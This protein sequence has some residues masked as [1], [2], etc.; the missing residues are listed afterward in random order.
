VDIT[1]ETAPLSEALQV[2]MR[3]VTARATRLSG[4]ILLKAATPG[5]LEVLGTDLTTVFSTKLSA[6]VRS[7][8]AQVVSGK[9][10]Q[11]V[12]KVLGGGSVEIREKPG[13]NAVELVSERSRFTLRTIPIESFP[14]VKPDVEGEITSVRL[15]KS[16]WDTAV[17]QVVVAAG[18]DEARPVFT[19]CLLDV[20]QGQMKLVATDSYR[21]AERVVEAESEGESKKAVVGARVL[22]E[23]TRLKGGEG[24]EILTIYLGSDSAAVE[25]G[26]SKLKSRYIE[27]VFPDYERLIPKANPNRLLAPRQDLIESIRRVSVLARD[28]TPVKLILSGSAVTVEVRDN[29]V[30]EATEEVEGATYSGEDLEVA[31]NPKY[32][33]DGLGGCEGE[34]VEVE[35]KDSLSAVLVHSE[36][37]EN[38]RHLIMPIRL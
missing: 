37:K 4:G 24:S 16:E 29:E 12:V 5:D 1:V 2:C 34:K 25:L 22:E 27:G 7:E 38:Y 19:G 33:L 14:E 11:D 26:E 13:E 21:L 15:A 28:V 32:L 9:W 10:L 23:V 31:F 35:I 20:D 18:V 36:E 3:L 8:G 17:T 30:G 6:E